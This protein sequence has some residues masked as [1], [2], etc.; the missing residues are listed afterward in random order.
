MRSITSA[1]TNTASSSSPRSRS[2]ARVVRVELLAL[3]DVAA[4]RWYVAGQLPMFDPRSS[5]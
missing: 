3:D 1:G 5:T 4:V 2:C